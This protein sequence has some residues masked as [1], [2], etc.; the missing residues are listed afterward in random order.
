M[1]PNYNFIIGPS[2]T[3][4]ISFCKVD[5]SPFTDEEQKFLLDEI[6]ELSPEFMEWEGDGYYKSCIALRA[7]NYVLYDGQKKLTKGSAFKTSTKEIALKE[8]MQELVDE[9]L[10]DNE[11]ST[12]IN[13]YHKYIKEALNVKDIHRWASKKTITEAILE[14]DNPKED[15]RKNEMDIWNAIKQESDIQEGTKFYIYPVIVSYNVQTGRIGKNGKPLKDKVTEITGYKL[16]KHWNNDH[17]VDKLVER[18]YSTLEIFKLVL[19]LTQF[20]D[21]T[22]DKNKI[23][24]Q[25]LKINEI[26]SKKY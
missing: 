14:C 8:F 2:D 4:S 11:M 20:I 19:D 23:L 18:V 5:M 1:N 9:M 6:N 24:L 21:Y 26:N 16:D 17:N 15:T 25:E 7:K 22:A 13:I 12:L 10:N 3:D